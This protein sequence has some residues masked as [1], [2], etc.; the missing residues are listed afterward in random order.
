MLSSM[1]G[2][3]A[4]TRKGA[5]KARHRCVSA[6]KTYSLCIVETTLFN[7]GFLGRLAQLFLFK[8]SH[9]SGLRLKGLWS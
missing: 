3:S 9:V 8:I 1:D 5:K 4:V 7:A 2:H 6:S